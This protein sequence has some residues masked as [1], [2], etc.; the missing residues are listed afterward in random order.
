MT[1]YT[2]TAEQRETLIDALEKAD[3]E[4]VPSGMLGSET[5]QAIESAIGLLESLKPNTQT[6][7]AWMQT[8][9]IGERFLV[10]DEPH[11]P[12]PL[13]DKVDPLFTHP[14]TQQKPLTDEQIQGIWNVAS[15]S[16]PGWCRHITYARAIEAAHGVKT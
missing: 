14:A 16:I 5:E 15:G 13:K 3:S 6:P 9:C 1:T 2:I 8:D 10:F 11:Q 12:S 7:T 4:V